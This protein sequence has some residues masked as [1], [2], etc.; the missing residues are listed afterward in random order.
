MVLLI[1]EQALIHLQELQRINLTVG[2]PFARELKELLELW[3][4][5]VQAKPLA[6]LQQ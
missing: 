3:A 6:S 2:Q 5:K 1:A 4:I